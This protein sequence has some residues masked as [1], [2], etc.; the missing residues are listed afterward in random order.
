M[1][2]IVIRKIIFFTIFFIYFGFNN[3]KFFGSWKILGG[4]GVGIGSVKV[5]P[6][7]GVVSNRI[8]VGFTDINFV[9]ARSAKAAAACG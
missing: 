2:W 5:N 8:G 6:G 3:L 9:V 7:S 1:N 4:G